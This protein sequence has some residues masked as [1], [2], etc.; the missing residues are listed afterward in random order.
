M[1]SARWT[2]Q[3]PVKATMSGWRSHHRVIAAVHSRA[4]RSACT[5]W[6]PSITLQ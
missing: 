5:S 4:R 1:I 3:R 6:Q 2:R